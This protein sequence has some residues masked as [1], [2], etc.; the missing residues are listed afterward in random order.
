MHEMIPDFGMIFLRFNFHRINQHIQYM[1]DMSVMKWSIFTLFE[2]CIALEI[3]A[4]ILVIIETTLEV[5][6][7]KV[8][9]R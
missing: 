4:H 7:K 2:F 1:I 5:R 9:T 3:L 8:Y 6:A